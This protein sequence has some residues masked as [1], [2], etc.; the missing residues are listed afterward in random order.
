MYLSSILPKR[1]PRAF[2]RVPIPTRVNEVDTF[3]STQTRII[4][5][6]RLCALSYHP[7]SKID[8]LGCST[9]NTAEDGC[10]PA[11]AAEEFYKLFHLL[12]PF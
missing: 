7:L 2:A 4:P 5:S 3:I 11:T 1:S 12:I 9:F 6:V 8:L 10:S